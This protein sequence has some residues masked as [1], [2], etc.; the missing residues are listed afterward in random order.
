[1]RGRQSEIILDAEEQEVLV[2]ALEI[3]MRRLKREAAKHRDAYDRQAWAK[4]TSSLR[5]ASH[6]YARLKIELCLLSSPTADE[7][8]QKRRHLEQLA[9]RI[10]RSTANAKA[11]H[12]DVVKRREIAE[13]RRTAFWE[14]RRQRSGSQ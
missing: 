6:V 9:E 2:Q 12:A 1:M 13:A 3:E 11:H 8:D 4:T 5:L 10:P 7:L 14:G